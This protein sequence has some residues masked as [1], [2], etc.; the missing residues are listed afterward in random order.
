[1]KI[2]VLI[3]LL[4]AN[5]CAMAREVVVNTANG[6]EIYTDRPC[7]NGSGYQGYRRVVV[8]YTEGY[9][10]Q[11]SLNAWVGASGQRGTTPSQAINKG[12]AQGGPGQPIEQEIPFCFEIN[13]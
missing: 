9:S 7:E 12:I 13:R 5:I 10:T 6:Q 1:M 3:V 4:A 11:R 8:G 2:W